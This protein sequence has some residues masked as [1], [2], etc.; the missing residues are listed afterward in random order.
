MLS[1]PLCVTICVDQIWV[2]AVTPPPPPGF[3]VSSAGRPDLGYC[4][5]AT[6]A[7]AV[8][9]RRWHQR[10]WEDL[11]AL[12][13][14]DKASSIMDLHYSAQ[15]KLIPNPTLWCMVD[16]LFE[17]RKIVLLAKKNHGFCCLVYVYKFFQFGVYY[18]L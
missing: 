7:A 6:T 12:S 8:L 18:V 11:D 17:V 9:R 1:P 13:T 4:C 14:G 10:I 2:A 15:E 3:T 5:R 16:A